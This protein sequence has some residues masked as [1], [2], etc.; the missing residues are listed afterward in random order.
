MAASSSTSTTTII[1]CK[2]QKKLSPASINAY[3]AAVRH[4][5]EMNNIDLKWK[6]INSFKG[7]LYNVVEHRPYTRQ[8]ISL[9]LQKAEPR[10]RAII[11]LKTTK[12]LRSLIMMM[13]TQ[14]KEEKRNKNR[15]P[16][17]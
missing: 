12:N 6:K 15:K 17:K 10:N 3:V 16:D 1:Y 14:I 9:L 11:L 4:F 5:Y 8:E 2:D 7:E 13:I